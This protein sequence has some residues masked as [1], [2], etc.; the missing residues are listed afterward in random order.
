MVALG[1]SKNHR[2]AGIATTTS[3]EPGKI[4]G[5]YLRNIGWKRASR[6]LDEMLLPFSRISGGFEW[7]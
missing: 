5:R 4:G 3:R 2:F 1:S 7:S 6:F